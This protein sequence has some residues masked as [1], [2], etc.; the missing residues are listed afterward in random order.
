MIRRGDV[1][2]VQLDQVQGSELDQDS[3][4]LCEQIRTISRTRLL[5]PMGQLPSERLQE[6]RQALDRHL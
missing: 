2:L 3:K 5:H 6:I 4:A 1:F